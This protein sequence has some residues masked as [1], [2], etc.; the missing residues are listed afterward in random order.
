MHMQ[1]KTLDMT[2][3]RP[4]LL[5]LQFAIPM[6]IGSIFQSL[7]SMV[8]TIVVG[9][10]VGA[11]ALAAIGAASSTVSLLMMVTN[12]VT[13][14]VSI[15]LSQ[16]FGAGNHKGIKAGVAAAG[17]MTVALGVVFGFIF[18]LLARPLMNLLNTP[19]NIIDGST[20]YI[21]LVCGLCVAQL[22]YNGAA[23]VLRA[24]G[25]SKTP[26][27]F[28]I[29]CSVMNVLL[30]LIAVI[31]LRMGVA[32]VALA[33]VCSQ[34]ISAVLC[35]IY[36]FRKYPELSLGKADIRPNWPVLG[37][38]ASL[39]GQ[40]ALQSTLLSVGMMV[41][42]RVIN[43]FGSDVVA[44]FTVGSN[45]QNLAAMLFSNFSFGF[46]VYVGQNYGA[47]RPD[48]IRQGVKE[49]TLLV[50]SLTL[51]AFALSQIFA[52]G[53]VGLYISKD[54]V[55][56]TA[57]ALKFVRIQSCFYPFL[58]WLWLYNS[59]LKGMGEIMYTTLSSVIE[60]TCKI[61]LSLLLPIWLG[62]TGIWL[63]A[64][65]GWIL[66]L[67]PGVAYYYSGKWVKKMEEK[68]LSA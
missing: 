28:L 45:V 26:L 42:T 20:I 9:R 32:G 25:D 33:T 39:G 30:D 2:R 29:L 8:D 21:K 34:A 62:Y 65:I 24:V 38:L 23:A 64:P 10:F 31:A 35:I 16:Y 13:S 51:L 12:G 22:A 3:G 47:R 46:S 48:R 44:A 66:G 56:I 57:A 11:E 41:I 6:M 36:M 63:S 1:N 27:Y 37:R 54:E 7:Y 50:G 4:V 55:A 15:V 14:A 61:A 58:G 40:M 60:L 19:A 67:V 18:F 5:M 52:N 59:T 68:P 17:H 49:I 43:G 53:L